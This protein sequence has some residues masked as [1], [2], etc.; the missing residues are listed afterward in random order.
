MLVPGEFE[1][2][3]GPV[4]GHLPWASSDRVGVEFLLILLDDH[5]RYDFES[6]QAVRQQLL[7]GEFELDDDGGLVLLRDGVDDE[8]GELAVKRVV[9]G[10][11]DPVIAENDVIGGHLRPV[12]ERSFLTQLD[13]VGLLVDLSRLLIGCQGSVGLSRVSG[14]DLVEPLEGVPVGSHG[15][16][17]GRRHRVV[18]VGP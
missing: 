6:G 12:R 10:I 1:G 16:G 13:L 5:L 7:K 8:I 14:F 9:L 15:Q 4:S 18:P 11:H 3:T 2:A 17:C